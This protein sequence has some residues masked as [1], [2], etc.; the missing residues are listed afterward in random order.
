MG[1]TLQVV[2]SFSESGSVVLSAAHAGALT[3]TPQVQFRDLKI[4][5]IEA[6]HISNV[7]L[8]VN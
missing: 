7:F 4:I 8:G 1:L 3:V 6:S 2:H 5:A